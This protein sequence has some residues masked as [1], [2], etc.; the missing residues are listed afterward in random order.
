MRAAA[1]HRVAAW[2]A[3]ER[4]LEDHVSLIV[5]WTPRF[6]G[7]R[8]EQRYRGFSESS[9][10]VHQT[11]IAADEDSGALDECRDDFKRQI[12]SDRADVPVR[13]GDDRLDSLLV[14]R[15]LEDQHPCP[16]LSSKP[17]RQF[18]E[19]LGRP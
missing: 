4:S 7:C 17:A 5:E 10:K 2:W 6:G 15:A 16:M 9:S 1:S 13:S 12:A 18:A 19:P 8:P 14:C 3:G 11:R